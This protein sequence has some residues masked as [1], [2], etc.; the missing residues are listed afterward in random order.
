MLNLIRKK[1][2]KYNY[3]VRKSDNFY[4]VANNCMHCEAI[5][6]DKYFYM[7]KKKVFFIMLMI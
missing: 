5:Q 4:Y 7:I 3:K 2:P 1:Y 6:D